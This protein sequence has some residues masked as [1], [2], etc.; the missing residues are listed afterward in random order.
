MATQLRSKIPNAI[1]Q[2]SLLIGRTPNQA[3]VS[4]EVIAKRKDLL[5]A[6]NLCI[7][8]SGLENKEVYLALDIDAGHFSNIRKGTS[9]S[10]FPTNKIDDLMTLCGNEIPLIW[11]G[12]KRGKGMHMLETEAQRLLRVEQETNAKLRDENRLLRE[13]AVGKAA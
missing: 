2:P 8:V 7:D 9:G 6:I 11:L 3:D 1:E 4:L 13:I 10:H 12:L 5:A